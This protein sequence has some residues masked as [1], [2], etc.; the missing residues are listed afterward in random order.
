MRHQIRAD[1]NGI[2]GLSFTMPRY[3]FILHNGVEGGRR[4]DARRADGYQHSGIEAKGFMTSALERSLPDLQNDI[5]NAVGSE[6][7]AVVRL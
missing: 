1:Q 2:W 4:T 7:D 3:G 5:A 6:V